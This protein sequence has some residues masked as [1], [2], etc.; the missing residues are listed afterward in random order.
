MLRVAVIYEA[1]E[2]IARELSRRAAGH[3]VEISAV[4][5]DELLPSFHLVLSVDDWG[6][7]RVDHWLGECT[8]A[9]LDAAWTDRILPFAT[10]FA[11][12]KRAPRK[13]VAEITPSTMEWRYSA[14]R[15]RER[16]SYAL[17]ARALRIDHIGSTSV[18][19]L[20]AKDLVDLQVVVQDL[21]VAE[22]CCEMATNAGFVPAG[23]IM[24]IDRDMGEQPEYCAVDA[25][26]GRPVNVHIR[27]INSP[28]W[29]D[30][31]LFRDW[32][33]ASLPA[34][35]EYE[36]M[37]LALASAPGSNVDSYSTLK[38]P[39]INEAIRRAEQWSEEGRKRSG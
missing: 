19:G 20:G 12:R 16:L 11:A 30:T 25:D 4:D 28:V 5:S 21:A 6:D 33:R 15:L 39:F 10:N 9:D 27:P 13:R 37:K 34:R 1:A 22:E 24:D 26:P 36:A 8:P 14:A 32:L 29:R 18:P 31:L 35:Q 17:G 23:Q 7:P 38:M 3:P 2:A